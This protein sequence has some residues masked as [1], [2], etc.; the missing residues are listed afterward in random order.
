MKLIFFVQSTHYTTL[1][2]THPI[3]PFDKN[4]EDEQT[5]GKKSNI[6]PLFKLIVVKVSL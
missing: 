4:E 1:A 3:T 6:V 2:N 5:R